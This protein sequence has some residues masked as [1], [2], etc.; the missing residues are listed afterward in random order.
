MYNSF[1]FYFKSKI[2]KKEHKTLKIMFFV[3]VNLCQLTMANTKT[4][5]IKEIVKLLRFN[6]CINSNIVILIF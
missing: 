5:S 2:I 1:L 4:T 6:Y 3:L